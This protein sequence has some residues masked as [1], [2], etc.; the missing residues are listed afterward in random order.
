[1]G[2]W[3]KLIN[4]LTPM[5]ST[6]VVNK[7]AERKLLKQMIKEATLD[8]EKFDQNRKAV[9]KKLSVVKKKSPKIKLTIDNNGE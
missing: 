3:T 1:M 4:F 6:V 2:F 7:V 8:L 9:K 5:S